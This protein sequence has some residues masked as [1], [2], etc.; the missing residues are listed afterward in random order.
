VSGADGER[1]KR[2][3]S[4]LAGD[5]EDALGWLDEQAARKR[6]SHEIFW[7]RG[8]ILASEGL[9]KKAAESLRT[10][11][12]RSKMDAPYRA[13]AVALLATCED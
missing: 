1:T 3:L 4:Y 7:W 12:E 10:Y 2:T 11:L 8:R 13:M 9:P 5:K 6:P